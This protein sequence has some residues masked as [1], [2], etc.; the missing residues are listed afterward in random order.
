MANLQ[1]L[2]ASLLGSRRSFVDPDAFHGSLL[3][4]P[5]GDRKQQ[6]AY[7]YLQYLLDTIG[8]L[9]NAR[10]VPPIRMPPITL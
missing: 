2:F 8:A 5:W 10:C 6:D 9:S 7:Q 4:E 1:V 3:K